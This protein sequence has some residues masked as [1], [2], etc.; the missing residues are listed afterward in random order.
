MELESGCRS[1]VGESMTLDQSKNAFSNV[2][3]SQ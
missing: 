1:I 2:L 3:I